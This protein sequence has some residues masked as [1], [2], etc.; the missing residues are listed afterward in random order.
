MQ[1]PYRRS[2]ILFSEKSV[3]IS[4]TRPA[5]TY[6]K[7][8]VFCEPFSR[9]LSFLTNFCTRFSTFLLFVEDLRICV[10]PTSSWQNDS[11]REEWLKLIHAFGGTKWFH[12]SGNSVFTTEIALVLQP[13]ETVLPAIH[14]LYIRGPVSCYEPLRE[15]V[16]LF[17]HSRLLSCH[18]I[19]VEYER[20]QRPSIYQVDGIGTTFV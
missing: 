1:M 3:S 14:K 16:A 6:F 20:R 10:T 2:D 5:S 9:R 17:V 8:Q 4:L 12:I 19:G 7:F 15:A 11:D 13:S 18:F